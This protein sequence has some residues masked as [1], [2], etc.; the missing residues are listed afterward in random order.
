MLREKTFIPNNIQSVTDDELINRI[1]VGCTKYVY[2]EEKNFKIVK[3]SKERLVT[4][5][6]YE[7]HCKLNKQFR[8]NEIRS[9]CLNIIGNV[10]Y[11]TNSRALGKLAKVWAL[12]PSQ[13]EDK[14]S[15][16]RPKGDDMSLPLSGPNNVYSTT[17]YRH[18]IEKL[19]KKE[20]PRA[21]IFRLL[22]ESHIIEKFLTFRCYTWF[23]Y[24]KYVSFEDMATVAKI[25]D[26]SLLEEA[27]LNEFKED[28]NRCQN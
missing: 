15:P 24:R 9:G 16:G 10:D 23:I 3:P 4:L 5:W 12:E 7:R 13:E 22:T 26:N 17:E 14:S 21:R 27:S 2:H 18:R 8:P 20:V 28:W 1:V 19:V 6:I 25:K 11:A